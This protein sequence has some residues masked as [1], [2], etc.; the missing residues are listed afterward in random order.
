[1]TKKLSAC[2]F[3]PIVIKG[4]YDGTM[5]CECTKC[6]EPCDVK[7]LSGLPSPKSSDMESGSAMDNPSSRAAHGESSASPAHELSPPPLTPGQAV[8]Q[9][10]IELAPFNNAKHLFFFGSSWDELAQ[11]AISADPVRKAAQAFLERIDLIEQCGSYKAVWENYAI[12]G[13]RYAGPQ[14]CD[15]REALRVALSEAAMDA[16]CKG[17]GFKENAN[18]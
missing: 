11:A 4:D 6:G 8:R 16:H 5:H 2:C 10:A 13:G 18:E 15:E 7:P 12:H 3:E 9:K 17:T 14:Y 1:M